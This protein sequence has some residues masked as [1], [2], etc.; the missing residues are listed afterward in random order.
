MDA[1]SAQ[2]LIF[3][4]I[5]VYLKQFAVIEERTGEPLQYLT[6][7]FSEPEAFQRYAIMIARGWDEMFE[8]SFRRIRL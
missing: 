1:D 5:G 8:R 6:K 3:V 4:R 2:P 7:Q